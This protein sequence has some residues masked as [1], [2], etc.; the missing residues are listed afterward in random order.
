MKHKMHIG[1]TLI[2]LNSCNS[3]YNKTQASN[4]YLHIKIK[5]R[6]E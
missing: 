3:I 6:E 5:L 2:T 4:S 1:T